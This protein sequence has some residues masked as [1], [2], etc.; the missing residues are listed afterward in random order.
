MSARIARLGR[1]VFGRRI[2]LPLPDGYA[3]II[4]RAAADALRELRARA[5]LRGVEVA[6]RTGIAKPI[7]YRI[8][9]GTHTP[10]LETCAAF[11]AAC[12]GSLLDVTRAIDA[13]LGWG[14]A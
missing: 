5:G 9:R 3:R 4:N 1:Q 2:D 12:G 10:T 13:A 7:V 6:R 8:E 11:A 14:D